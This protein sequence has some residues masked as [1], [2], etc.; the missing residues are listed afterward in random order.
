MLEQTKSVFHRRDFNFAVTEFSGGPRHACRQR[1]GDFHGESQVCRPF[2][3]H[4]IVATS[5][6]TRY[7]VSSTLEISR[8]VRLCVIKVTS[9]S[10]APPV[11]AETYTYT[12]FLFF[13]SFL[14]FYIGTCR[15][16][17]DQPDNF[18]IPR[19]KRSRKLTRGGFWNIPVS[20]EVITRRRY[21]DRAKD[22]GTWTSSFGMKRHRFASSYSHEF[23]IRTSAITHLENG[24]IQRRTIAIKHSSFCLTGLFS[25]QIISRPVDLNERLKRFFS[26]LSLHWN[27]LFY[28]SN[29]SNLVCKSE[30]T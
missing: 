29:I 15:K 27:L 9:C 22:F 3:S 25:F 28:F 8:N 21:E 19:G 14:L 18:V 5:L 26:E 7:R 20:N 6:M 23:I 12:R 1:C 13:F 16:S 10:A 17:R 11:I 2:G 30:R 4:T 24:R